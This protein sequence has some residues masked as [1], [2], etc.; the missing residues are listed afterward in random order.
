MANLTASI[1][2]KP[3]GALPGRTIDLPVKAATQLYRGG[4]VA[5]L[6]GVLVPFTTAN[7]G[8][9]IGMMNN[10]YLGGAADGDQRAPVETDRVFILANSGDVDETV[11]FGAPLFGTDD[12]TVSA[13]SSS[14]TRPCAGFFDG[15][16]V[17]AV[18]TAV[19]VRVLVCARE[20]IG[21]GQAAKVTPLVTTAL[22]GAASDGTVNAI[23]DP[24]DAPGT[25]DALRD[26]LVANT[27]PKVR[28]A[29]QEVAD[30][31]TAIIAALKAAG[32]MSTV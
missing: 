26:D 2:P 13:S 28:D 27:I 22:A 11:A 7:A 4:L 1:I 24:A 10:E 25:A 5:C 16:E 21:G 31:Q 6:A 18:G 14:G 8:P 23:P 30:K 12:H 20:A 32:L 3:T 17:D 15:M 19:G 29:L 9:A